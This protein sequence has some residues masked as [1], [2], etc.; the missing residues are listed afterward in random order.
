MASKISLNDALATPGL[1]P[2]ARCALAGLLSFRNRDTGRCDPT[3]KALIERLG[4]VQERTLFRWLAELRQTG[5]L[6][7]RRHDRDGRRN[8]YVIHRVENQK[9]P[10]RTVT[11]IPDKS[12]G[13]CH[14]TPLYEP[15]TLNRRRSAAAEIHKKPP[16]KETRLDPAFAVVRHS[17]DGLA[18]AVHRPRP[19]DDLVRLVIAAAPGCTGEEIAAC[20]VA[21]WKTGRFAAMRGWG[22]VPVLV[23]SCYQQ[24]QA[25]VG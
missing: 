7:V 1:S 10:D 20:L 9:L 19:D 6:E 17:L 16:A 8:L 13:N 24:A 22:L 14:P 23:A 4:S 2:G 25:A 21:L 15:D 5:I 3:L 12:V 18:E 11:Q